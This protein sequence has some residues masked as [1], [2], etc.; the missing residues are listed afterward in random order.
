MQRSTNYTEMPKENLLVLVSVW[1]IQLFILVF[2]TSAHHYHQNQILTARLVPSTCL[3]G[4]CQASFSV[5][6]FTK[7]FHPT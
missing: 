6:L 3:Y 5:S 7:R 2:Y 1:E 4:G